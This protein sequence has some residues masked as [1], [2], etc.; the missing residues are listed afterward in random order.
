MSMATRRK[1]M[2]RTAIEPSAR[3]NLTAASP[4][5]GTRSDMV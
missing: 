1:M 4:V 2:M 3:T 5:A